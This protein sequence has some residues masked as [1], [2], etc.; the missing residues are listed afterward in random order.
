MPNKLR[1]VVLALFLAGA[2]AGILG[3]GGSNAPSPS[4]PAQEAA[5]L[6]S[7]IDEIQANVQVGSCVV[8]QTKADDLIADIQNLPSTVNSD[9]K[10]ALANGANQLKLLLAD[11]SKCQGR[12]TTAQTTTSTPST[13]ESTTTRP[14]PTTTSTR[15]QTQAT[16]TTQT[17]TSPSTTTGGSGGIGPGGL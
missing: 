15:T 4:I 13:T 8:A 10:T 1:S 7:K 14:N 9:V 6:S 17:Q 5:V 3:C 11:P 12:T 2:S 16:T